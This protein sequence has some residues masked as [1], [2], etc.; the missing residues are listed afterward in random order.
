MEVQ[1]SLHH[2]SI[3]LDIYI[4]FSMGWMNLA[5]YAKSTKP[6]KRKTITLYGM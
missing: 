5:H 2:D 3:L 4:P 6:D 1:I